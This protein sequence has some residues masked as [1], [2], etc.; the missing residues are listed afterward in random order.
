MRDACAA[1]LRPVTTIIGATATRGGG[2]I[3]RAERTNGRQSD[4][5][6]QSD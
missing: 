6:N 5:D 1:C 2:L 4:S 3:S